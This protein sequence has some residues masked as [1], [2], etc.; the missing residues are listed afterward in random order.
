MPQRFEPTIAKVVQ[1]GIAVIRQ[2][3]PDD[4]VEPNFKMLQCARGGL[5]SGVQP[6]L[7]LMTL[8]TVHWLSFVHDSKFFSV[9]RD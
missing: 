1:L 4:R 6:F 3:D 9:L 2:K 8:F 5:V 7:V